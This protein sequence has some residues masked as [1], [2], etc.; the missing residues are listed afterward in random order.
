MTWKQNTIGLKNFKESL[1][2]I[3]WKTND[4][5]ANCP[6][7]GRLI[8]TYRSLL[9]QRSFVPLINKHHLYWFCIFMLSLVLMF[10]MASEHFP[11]GLMTRQC[12]G[13]TGH[14]T[15]REDELLKRLTAERQ[16]YRTLKQ[17][18]TRYS[19]L[20]QN[21]VIVFLLSHDKGT[22]WITPSPHVTLSNEINIFPLCY[23]FLTF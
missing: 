10:M 7:I 12:T 11:Q 9:V 14:F 20:T 23:L 16:N 15:P 19:K 18:T 5:K 3:T 17:L 1:K 2:S 13:L 21:S 6:L 22:S 8:M 4:M